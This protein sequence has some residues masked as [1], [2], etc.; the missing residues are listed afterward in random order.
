MMG[1]YFLLPSIDTE[2]MDKNRSS[3]FTI[4]ETV[5][6]LLILSFAL[7][8]LLTLVQ[9]TR[10]RAF[11]NYQDR[12][13]LLRLDS[14]LQKIKYYHAT[15]GVFNYPGSLSFY[16]PEPNNVQ[17]PQVLVHAVFSNTTSWDNTVGS[18]IGYYNL[19]VKAEW[20]ARKL[21]FKQSNH[22]ALKKRTISL[23]EDYFFENNAE[24]E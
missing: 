5:I 19:T 20:E 16:I 18:N 3:G 14:E 8:G 10:Y 24:E 13:V 22:Q 2:R 12:Y 11:D 21:P 1:S 9:Y 7:A 4:L 23:R 15:Y 6:S 17:A